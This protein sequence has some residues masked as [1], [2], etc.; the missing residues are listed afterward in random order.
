MDVLIND[1]TTFDICDG[2]GLFG[3][4]T[5]WFRTSAACFLLNSET[6]HQ[7]TQHVIIEATRI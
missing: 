3:M 4:A 7:Q 1:M 5:H 2:H 6:V